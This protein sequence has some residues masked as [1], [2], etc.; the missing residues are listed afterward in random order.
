MSNKQWDKSRET[1]LKKFEK[2]DGKLFNKR[3]IIEINKQNLFKEKQAVNGSKGGRPKKEVD[4][5]EVKKEEKPNKPKPFSGLTQTKPKKRSSSSFSSSEKKEEVKEERFPYYI[6]DQGFVMLYD[7]LK[8]RFHFLLENLQRLYPD[9]V[10]GKALDD[11]LN[12]NLQKRWGDEEDFRSHLN[13]SF[14]MFND[15]NGESIRKQAVNSNHRTVN[16]LL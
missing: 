2:K 7:F 11:F 5:E 13:N 3:L 10:Y 12:K 9:P 15:K 4:N 6:G 14:K 1:I 16:D 8:V